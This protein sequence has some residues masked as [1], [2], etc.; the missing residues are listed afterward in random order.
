VVA[1]LGT[2]YLGTAGILPATAQP[3]AGSAAPAAAL[4]GKAD[5]P[6]WNVG[7]EWTY[8]WESQRGKG[9]FTSVVDREEMVDGAV[10]YVMVT[11]PGRR[12]GAS[13]TWAST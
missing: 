10:D 2:L 1:T 12:T 13:P 9:T 8:R 7:D 5:L 11:G 6:V 4:L 3:G